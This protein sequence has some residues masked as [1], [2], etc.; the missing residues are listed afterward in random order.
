MTGCIDLTGLLGSED[1]K[2]RVD[3]LN[4]IAYDPEKKRLFVTGKLWPKIFE[5]EIISLNK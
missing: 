1:R 5:I 4:G 3:C 2:E